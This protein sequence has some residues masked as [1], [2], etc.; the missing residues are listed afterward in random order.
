MKFHFRYWTVIVGLLLCTSLVGQNWDRGQLKIFN[1]Y[2]ELEAELSRVSDS[3][4]L[5]NYW[6]T[7]CSPCVAELPYIEAVYEL[8]KEEK[9]RSILVSLDFK[10]QIDSKL[11]PFLNKNNIQSE[12]FVL[13][14]GKAHKWIDK[15]DPSWS[16]AIPVTKI[17]NKNKSEFYE[18]SF[19]TTL[20][21][22]TLVTKLIND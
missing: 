19:H 9:Y 17:F 2:S 16:G 7:W 1:T 14:D 12:V 10:N 20:E 15:V 8:H 3:T 11:I 6:A 5:V 21:L 4:Y 13:L 22:D 18:K